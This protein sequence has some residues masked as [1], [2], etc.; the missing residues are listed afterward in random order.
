M[1]AASD[2]QLE[3]LQELIDAGHLL[4][5]GVPGVYGHSQAYEHV[6]DRLSAVVSEL[7][8]ASG[9]TR[10]S[11]PPVLPRRELETSGYVGKFPHLAGSIFGFEGTEADARV[12]ADRAD[13]HQDWSEFQGQ[14]DLMLL[15][16]ACYPVYP[17]LAARGPVA[18]E[19]VTVDL[20]GA[21][22]F[23]HEPSHDP[24]RRQIF[25]MHEIVRVGQAEEVA[26]WRDD[27]AQRGVHLFSELGLDGEL[28]NAN[29]P[30]F[31]RVGR[32]LAANQTAGE[33]KWELAVQIAGPGPTACASFN[34]HLDHFADAWDLKLADGT[35]AHTACAGF[36][37]DRIVLALL[38]THG[39]DPDSWPDYVQR[40]LGD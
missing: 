2:D 6:C 25:R 37:Q 27:W 20:G 22:V 38:R 29:D 14:T 12:Q 13:A 24:A 5:S 15:P 39:V 4:K 23:R 36:G 34:Y 35:S 31:G 9:A 33:L 17:A 30:F 32:L 16:A 1:P 26:R 7:A 21:W 40:R 8:A 18:L 3:L 28:A 19:G 11:F 10:L